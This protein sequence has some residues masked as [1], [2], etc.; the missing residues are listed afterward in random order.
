MAILFYYR[1]CLETCPAEV[2]TSTSSEALPYFKDIAEA[3]SWFPKFQE[4]ILGAAKDTG[5]E[6]Q[7]VVE[8]PSEKIWQ[9]YR[10][11]IEQIPKQLGAEVLVNSIED[12]QDRYWVVNVDYKVIDQ[13]GQ[14][15]GIG[16]IQVDIGNA[17]RLDI[18]YINKD[19][20]RKPLRRTREAHTT[21]RQRITT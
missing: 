15:R 10:E 7:V 21:M 3:F 16:C 11:Y 12:D 6:Y 4:K 20:E 5:R 19:G 13:L 17:P 14:A 9:E 8:V 1:L 18:H 2:Y